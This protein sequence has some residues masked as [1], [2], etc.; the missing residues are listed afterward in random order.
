MAQPLAAAA[1]G[2]GQSPASN[3]VYTKNTKVHEVH[4]EEQLLIAFLRDLRVL[5]GSIFRPFM[6]VEYRDPAL[7]AASAGVSKPV[8]CRTWADGTRVDAKNTKQS[9]CLLGHFGFF[10]VQSPAPSRPPTAVR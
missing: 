7:P 3:S 9:N 4:E 2:P 10:V 1:L 5:R 6:A 8:R